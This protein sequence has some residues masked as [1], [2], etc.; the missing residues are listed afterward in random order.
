LKI[1]EIL[2]IISKYSEC[3]NNIKLKKEINF[4]LGAKELL[5]PLYKNYG[6]D[7]NSCVKTL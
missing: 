5:L 7:A 1:E 4:L 3:M 2:K 6:R